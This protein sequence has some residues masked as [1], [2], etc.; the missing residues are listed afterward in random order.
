MKRKKEIAAGMIL[1][2]FVAG[3]AVSGQARERE[4]AREPETIVT[5]LI[6][7]TGSENYGAWMGKGAEKLLLDTNIR[8][9]L[10]PN[11]NGEKLRQYM[12]AGTLPDF[13]GFAT[14]QAGLLKN[15]D[16]L[17]NLDEYQEFLPAVFENQAYEKALDYCRDSFGGETEGLYLLPTKV[18]TESEEEYEWMPMLQWKPYEQAGCPKMATLQDYLDAAEAMIRYKPTTPLGDRVYGFSLFGDQDDCTVQGA[19]E[20]SYLYGVD[21]GRISPLI[22]MDGKT[23]KIR[24]VLDEDSFYKKGLAFYY[25]ANQR[26]LLDPDSRTQTL[27][28]LKQKYDSGRILFANDS[29][30]VEAYNQSDE[31]SAT[32]YVPVVAADMKIYQDSGFPVGTDFY[33]G[34]SRNAADPAKACEVLNWLYDEKTIAELYSHPES[35]EPFEILGLS[36]TEAGV[37]TKP[38]PC[39]EPDQKGFEE[40][41]TIG[42]YLR[43]ED[44]IQEGS[45]AVY[46]LPPDPMRIQNLTKKIGETVR[47]LSWDMIYA[48][49]REEFEALWKKMQRISRMIGLEEIESYYQTVW[50]EALLK[51]EAYGEAS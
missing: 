21:T 46:M 35:L 8:L 51:E 17:L 39:R 13:I 19:G 7:R 22:E 49:D 32:D 14:S 42:E 29:R 6:F 30:M 27:D 23:K 40:S 25:E 44:Q 20:L 15:A 1:A 43:E 2:V 11:G 36:K 47:E 16:L 48:E 37:E 45:S 18:G 50:A 31:L 10:Y 4:S 33:Y 41:K 38:L 12:A 28:G 24:T 3:S 9:E 34:I 5:G 26:G